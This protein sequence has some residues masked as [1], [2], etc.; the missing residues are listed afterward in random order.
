MDIISLA[1]KT[2]DMGASDLHL[3]VGIP[4]VVRIDGKLVKLDEYQKLMPDDIEKI[5]FEFLDEKHRDMLV[6]K[7]EVDFSHSQRGI[8]RFRVNAYRQRGSYSMALRVVAL[9][10]PNIDELRLP[11]ILK[12]FS[13]KQRG[14]VLVTGPTGSGKTTTLAAMIDHINKNRNCHILTL[15]DPIEYLHKH[16]KGIVNQREIGNDSVS[17][18]NALRAAL[19]QDPD[20]ILI[21]EMRDL[22]TISIALT[23]AETGHLVFS[24]LHTMGAVST[25]ERIIDVFPPAQQNQIKIQLASVLHGVVSQQ[26]VRKLDGN[27]RIAATEIMVCNSAIRNHIREGKTHQI[28]S[29]LQTGVKFGMHTMDRSIAE[30]YRDGIVSYEDALT[31][32]FD[33]DAFSRYV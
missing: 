31:C 15:E 21:G 14:L 18:S 13:L 24:T 28:M 9:D 17:Y 5:V 2:V 30:L 3:S 32:A 33:K 19:R 22:E 25:I 16:D 20:V 29:S 8:G 12:D 27:G 10:I 6:E 26:L 23:A 7:G 11:E 1:K 4:P